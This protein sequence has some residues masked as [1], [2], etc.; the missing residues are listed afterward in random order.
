MSNSPSLTL[1]APALDRSG[2]DGKWQHEYEA[3]LRLK[4]PLLATHAGQY[5]VVHGGVVVDSGPDDVALALR[6][7]AK[8]G[9]VPVHIGL[10]TDQPETAARIPHY[11]QQ[12][13]G[14]KA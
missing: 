4:A 14:D 10:V 13:S 5:V 6:F 12:G 11:R 9:N 8:Q 2:A 3:F 7:F 1:P